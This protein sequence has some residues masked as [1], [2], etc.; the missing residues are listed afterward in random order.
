MMKFTGLDYIKIAIANAFGLDKETW[1][2]R[3]AWVNNNTLVL[4]QYISSAAEPLLYEKAVLAY[5]EALDGIPSHFA[6]SLDSTAS[7]LQ[8]YAVL[9]GCLKTAENSNLVNTG[10]REDVYDKIAI[11]MN[12]LP[13]VTVTRMDVKKPVMTSFYGSTNQP[14]SIF[15]INTPELYAFYDAL[16]MEL[17]GAWE[18]MQDIQNCWDP[19]ALQYSWKLPDGY[20]VIAK[21]MDAVDKKVEVE[22]FGKVTFTHR[23]IINT[24]K[25]KGRSLAANVIHS[26]DGYVCREMIRR[27]DFDLYTVHDA[28]FSSPNNMQ[29]VRETYMEILV[30]I[31]DSD[32]LSDILTDIC[33]RKITVNKITNNLSSAMSNAEY[34]LS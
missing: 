26:V 34:A 27:C 11:T 20:T 12:K 23:A 31:A 30:E 8:M 17:P 9:T 15:G 2:T 32:L 14:M 1:D 25:P 3:L 18:A 19:S 5:R 21:V 33:Q 28:Y 24:P 13:D 16:E 29:K 10:N 4:N 22:E 6:M 7:G